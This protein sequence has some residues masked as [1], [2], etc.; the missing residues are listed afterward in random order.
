MKRFP[1]AV[2][3]LL[4]F[5]YVL[6]MYFLARRLVG[7]VL[8]QKAYHDYLAER[9]QAAE[10]RLNSALN[11]R[12][13]DYIVHLRLGNV[14]L[15]LGKRETEAEQ[16]FMVITKA[17]AC[18]KASLKL[19]PLEIETVYGLATAE[20]HLEQLFEF[21]YP[22]AKNNPFQPLKYYDR[23]IQL[24]PNGM[25][26][27]YA[28]ARCLYRHKMN[29]K[30][31]GA[32]RNLGRID[33]YVYA[34][35]KKEEF[36]TP[37]MARVFME[38]LQQASLNH[39]QKRK[40]HLAMAEMSAD[41]ENWAGAIQ[42]YQ[43][44][45]T[46]ESFKNNASQ[47]CNL[48]LMHLKNENFQSAKDG[49]M[50][51]MEMSGS[52]ESILKRIY[53]YY[54][55][56]E[57]LDHFVDFYELA[58]NRFYLS[59]KMK[60]LAAKALIESSR[61]ERARALLQDIAHQRPAAEIWYQL[62]VLYKQINDLDNWELAI[63][64]AVMLDPDNSHYHDMFSTVLLKQGKL[65]AAE[66]EAGLAIQHRSTPS[67]RLFHIRATIRW[68]KKNY[69]G[70]AADW[71]AARE[72]KPAGAVFDYHLGNVCART[73]NIEKA[74]QYYRNALALQPDN[75]RYMDLVRRFQKQAVSR[76]NSYAPE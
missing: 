23:T 39:Y 12:P 76:N 21:L 11:I 10:H 45:F 61:I 34:M 51:A 44:A 40:A 59:S 15:E 30:L 75:Q 58:V 4:L 46:V 33:P 16:S 68:K 63:H 41:D 55:Q 50:T 60:I 13:E 47:Y 73:G 70:A 64:K 26:C 38:G 31:A 53:S 42:H 37:E 35:M 56:E 3:C 36:W 20:M 25:F 66:R 6:A 29:E 49:F 27:N 74:L 8:M 5:L 54:N 2:N 48:G 18:F 22:A 65:D 24:W 7:A 9:F 28:R 52:I 57:Q 19:N 43:A 1:R 17:K 71:K 69:P 67:V 14:Y 72:L 62:A 32:V